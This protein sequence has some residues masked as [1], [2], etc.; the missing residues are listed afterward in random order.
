MSV[1]G[2]HLPRFARLRYL[3]ILPGDIL[4]AVSVAGSVKRPGNDKRP[5]GGPS[6]LLPMRLLE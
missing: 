4:P 6:L 2:G 5:G 1:A 3:R